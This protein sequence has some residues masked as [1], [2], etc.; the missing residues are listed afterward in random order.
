M[1]E[2]KNKNQDT[3]DKILKAVEKEHT[4]RWVGMV[5][6]LLLSLATVITSWCVYQSTQWDGEQY[7]HIE[8]INISDR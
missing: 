7:F 5:S 4:T 2:Q 3:L 8:D 6:T 1:A